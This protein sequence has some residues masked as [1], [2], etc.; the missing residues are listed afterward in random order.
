ME[1]VAD[2]AEVGLWH[3]VHDWPVAA[4]VRDSVWAYPALETVHIIGLALVFGSI[5]AYDLRILGWDRDLPVSRLGAKLLPWVWAGF[6]LNLV[7][8][9]LLF[10]SDAAEFAA[11]TSFRAKMVLL[12]LAA[13]NAFW[14]QA[15]VAR[16][17]A[18]WDAGVMP[19]AAARIAAGLSIV[20]WIG[21]IT[22][23]RLMAYVK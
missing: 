21:V 18:A 10:A 20:L 9:A 4:L 16:S 14:F 3:T 5:L 23:G 6:A 13:L 12:V 15:R 19:P 7:S 1:D 11:N 8:G 17:L 2:A 22:A